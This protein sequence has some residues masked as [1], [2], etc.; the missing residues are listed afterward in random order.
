MKKQKVDSH[1][2]TAEMSEEVNYTMLDGIINNVQK[3]SV[4]ERL[5]EFE[6][7][8]KERHHDDFLDKTDETRKQAKDVR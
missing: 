3:P 7:K 6:Q 8:K 1:L 4:L 5:E 2:A